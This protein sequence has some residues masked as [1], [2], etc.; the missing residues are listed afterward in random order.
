MLRQY[1]ISTKKSLE[2]RVTPKYTNLKFN[3]SSPAAKITNKKAQNTRIKYEIKF[4]YKKKA[5]LN[6][7]LYKSH[8]EAA[9]EW[10]N[11]WYSIQRS[12]CEKLNYEM[13]KNYKS[14]DAKISKLAHAQIQKLLKY[15]LIVTCSIFTLKNLNEISLLCGMVIIN[16]N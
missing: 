12:T 4:L 7:S 1:Y 13:E 11:M 16:H 8:L 2:K 9:K 6:H 5:K 15:S 14:L 3:N 10:G